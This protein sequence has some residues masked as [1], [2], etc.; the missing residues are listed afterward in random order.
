MLERIVTGNAEAICL[1]ASLVIAASIFVA[2]AWRAL[3]M[4]RPDVGRFAQLP[5]E[6]PTPAASRR[7]DER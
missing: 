4:K 2:V 5:F 1:V 6:T 3:R 7:P